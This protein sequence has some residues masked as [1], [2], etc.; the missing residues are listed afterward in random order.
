MGNVPEPESQGDVALLQSVADSDRATSPS[1]SEATAQPTG[2]P[3]LQRYWHRL[4]RP[5]GTTPNDTV[6]QG[7]NSFSNL[8]QP[9][10][11]RS[12]LRTILDSL[13]QWFHVT[14]FR[15]RSC[16]K[17]FYRRL[18]IPTRSE[19][20]MAPEEHSPREALRPLPENRAH[21]DE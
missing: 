11:R 20:Q 8:R 18:P 7:R 21:T 13:T 14:P 19:V 12:E 9:Q 16:W 3:R 1:A 17:R 6:E 4:T 2:T 15:C 10:L 5:L